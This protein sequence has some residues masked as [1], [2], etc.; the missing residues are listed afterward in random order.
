MWCLTS[1][2]LGVH[3]VERVWLPIAQVN[4]CLLVVCASVCST[5]RHGKHY[6]V[7]IVMDTR[8]QHHG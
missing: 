3:K 1:G 4:R 7:L 8:A 2:I 6:I 5:L